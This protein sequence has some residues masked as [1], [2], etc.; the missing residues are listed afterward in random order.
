MDVTCHGLQLR[1]WLRD[2]LE[3]VRER[4]QAR[5]TTAPAIGATKHLT[6]NRKAARRRELI[7]WFRHVAG[8]APWLRV[9]SGNGWL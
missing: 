5:L 7:A 2:Q 4:D 9:L 1:Y 8:T 6:D 3:T